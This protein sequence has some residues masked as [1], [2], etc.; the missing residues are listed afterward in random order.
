MTAIWRT[1]LYRAWPK[2]TR[3]KELQHLL[4]GILR[5]RNRA[6]RAERLFSSAEAELFP[7]FGGFRRSKL[8]GDL[9][10]EAARWLY[11]DDGMTLIELFCEGALHRL[12]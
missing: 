11:G 7:P 9:C 3:G 5:V 1:Y 10:P 6:A 4:N 2:G 12:L 8:L